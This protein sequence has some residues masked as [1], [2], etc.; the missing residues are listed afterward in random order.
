MPKCPNC[1]EKLVKIIYGYPTAEAFEKSQ[2]KQLYL[3]GCMI[4]I[5]IEQ[6]IYHCYNCSRNYCKN[7]KDYIEVKK[8]FYE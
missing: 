4:P 2:K 5:G 6:P 8:K 7:L 1:N 3:G